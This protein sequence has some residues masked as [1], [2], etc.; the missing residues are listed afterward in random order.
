MPGH[1]CCTVD[2]VSR[3]LWSTTDVFVLSACSLY[4]NAP[5]L[6]IIN[7]TEQT[8]SCASACMVDREQR[9]S[10]KKLK[11]G[12]SLLFGKIQNNVSMQW[13]HNYRYIDGMRYIYQCY[14]SRGRQSASTCQLA[15]ILSC[16][17]ACISYPATVCIYTVCKRTIVR[18]YSARHCLCA[19]SSARLLIVTVRNLHA[20][21]FCWLPIITVIIH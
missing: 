17:L 3:Y 4:T 20:A 6:V 19:G 10:W 15:C 11:Y 9:F 7:R 5:V 1:R 2:C 8:E 14:I 21:A 16:I 12:V 13:Q 18:Q